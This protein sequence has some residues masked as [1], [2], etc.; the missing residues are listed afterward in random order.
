M[1]ALLLKGLL[2]VVV[3]VG[4]LFAT[5]CNGSL[6][7]IDINGEWE[8]VAEDN[9]PSCD[10]MPDS[11]FLGGVFRQLITIIQTGDQVSASGVDN[12]GNS[13]SMWGYQRGGRF[14]GEWEL[15]TPSR[16]GA[17][18]R[19]EFSSFGNYSTRNRS[20]DGFMVVTYD[21][22]FGCT[23][24]QFP[25]WML[26]NG[27]VPFEIP[28]ELG[29]ITQEDAAIVRACSGLDVVFAMDTSGSMGDESQALCDA[30]SAVENALITLG[31]P[32]NRLRVA[33]KGITGGPTYSGGFACLDDSIANTYGTPVPGNPS[34]GEEDLDDSEDWGP[35]IAVIA[36]RRPW[37]ANA[38]R[39][40]VAISDEAPENG[41]GSVNSDDRASIDNS[42]VIANQNNVKV[43][44]VVASG[45]GADILVEAQRIAAATGG[46]AVESSD[47]SLDLAAL[48]LRVLID[49]CRAD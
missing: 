25:F 34:S 12:W 11:M 28:P 7:I 33:L 22:E 9:Q 36:D 24:I 10:A 49:S 6:V 38:V 41:G 18:R 40:V 26:M 3:T 8:F 35:V 48:V 16:T 14:T 27:G 45:A 19:M 13:Y 20:I 2:V 17:P 42:I 32:A 47:P 15:S 44:V 37:L 29:D 46:S 43:S 31:M 4:C 30:V 39:V 23:G 1:R 5:A 21:S